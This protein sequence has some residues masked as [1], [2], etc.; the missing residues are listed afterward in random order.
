LEAERSIVQIGSRYLEIGVGGRS[1][2]GPLKLEYLGFSSSSLSNFFLIAVLGPFAFRFVVS[3]KSSIHTYL[4]CPIFFFFH[5]TKSL[6]WR[7]VWSLA[8]F[9]FCSLGSIWVVFFSLYSLLFGWFWFWRSISCR[10]FLCFF[11]FVLWLFLLN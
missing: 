6:F 9:L 1:S 4:H 8:F 7:V 3:P 5:I 11:F 10:F 2:F